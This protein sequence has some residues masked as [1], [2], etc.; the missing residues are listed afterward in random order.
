M[1]MK[2]CV[3]LEIRKE[4]PAKTFYGQAADVLVQIASIYLDKIGVLL[5]SIVSANSMKLPPAVFC[6]GFFISGEACLVTI[7]P[8]KK[9][10]RKGKYC[11]W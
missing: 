3:P 1:V 8:N 2:L 7:Y 10:L 4:N 5:R 11:Q 6:R 9:L